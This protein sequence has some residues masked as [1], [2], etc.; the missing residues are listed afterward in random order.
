MQI[1]RLL[2][3]DEKHILT[4]ILA[5]AHD[6]VEVLNEILQDSSAKLSVQIGEEDT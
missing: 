2:S 6:V 3:R 5:D 4:E 1:V